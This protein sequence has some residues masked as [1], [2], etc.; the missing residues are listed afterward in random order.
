MGH[1]VDTVNIHKVLI[2][3]CEDT[4]GKTGGSVHHRV[5]MLVFLLNG[6]LILFCTYYGVYGKT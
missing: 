1:F 4:Y 6:R 2:G 3:F 5:V